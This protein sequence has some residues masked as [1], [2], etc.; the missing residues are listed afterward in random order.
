MLYL[1]RMLPTEILMVIL[2]ELDYETLMSAKLV[3]KKWHDLVTRSVQLWK[4]LIREFCLQ[5]QNMKQCLDMQ[6]YKDIVS[7]SERL[8]HLYRKLRR[9]ERNVQS[10]NYRVRTI[11]CLLAEAD[12]KKVEIN[13]D[14]SRDHNYKGV[15]DM[16]LSKN[17][18]VA[19]VYDT[20]QIWDMARY[21]I[22]NI[23]QSKMLDEPLSKTTCFTSVGDKYLVCGT[24]DG[25]M[26][27]FSLPAGDFLT[28]VKIN[29]NYFTDVC[30]HDGTVCSLDWYGGITMWEVRDTGGTVQLVRKSSEDQFIVPR[31]LS[32]REHERLLDFT[33]DFLVTSYKCHLT[34]YNQ[35]KF[36]RSYPATTDIFCIR[37]QGSRLA[38]GCKGDNSNNYCSAG[39]LNLDPSMFP[40][41][42]YLKT[43]DNDPIISIA[44]S[45]KFLILGDTNG[46]LH[47]VNI[48][49]LSFPTQGEVTVELWNDQ[50]EFGVRPIST[51]RTHEYGS[52]IWACKSDPYRI[53]SG[54]ENGK[55]IVHDFLMFED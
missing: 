51:I 31:I 27:L 6:I 8:Q 12:G 36:F 16:V 47:L 9:V 34:C 43:R 41:V 50:N 54:D 14:W 4:R 49:H 30:A 18:L 48:E 32:N 35:S 46:E 21:K 5:N 26:K 1:Y 55:I 7:D 11:D 3:C 17:V 38:F 44:F 28:K 29:S 40:A 24:Q 25:D 33:S 39:I 45:G 13:S 2:A 10:N 23:L 37:I 19:S 22:C 15:Y 53:F 42:I 20:I 52:F